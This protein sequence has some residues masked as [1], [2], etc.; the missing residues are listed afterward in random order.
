MAYK[1]F[2]HKVYICL[3]ILFLFICF[4]SRNDTWKYWSILPISFFSLYL[5]GKS[6]PPHPL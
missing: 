4:I 5:V 1:E 3:I 6:P 2:R